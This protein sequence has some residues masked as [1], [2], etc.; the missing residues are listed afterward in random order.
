M[1]TGII[2]RIGKID[3]VESGSGE[4]GR[5][6][7]ALSEAWP[8]SLVLGE[9]IAVN[10]VCLTLAEANGDILSFDVLQETFDKT[11]L[12]VFGPGGSG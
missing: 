8:D 11:M 7:L 9:S 10:G 2:E 1:F 6:R 3:H 5:L 4:Q 12:G